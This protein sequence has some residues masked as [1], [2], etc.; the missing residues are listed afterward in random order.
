DNLGDNTFDTVELYSDVGADLWLHYFEDRSNTL[1]GGTFGNITDSRL[2]I[3]GIP[4]GT[5]PQEEINAIFTMI[6][7]APGSSNLPGDIPDRLSFI[8][9]IKNF[10]GDS[11]ANENDLTLPVNPAAP[12]ATLIMVAGTERI[13]SLSYNSTLMRGGYASDVSSLSIHVENLPEVLILKGSFQLSSTGLSRVNFNNPNLNTISQLLDNALLTVVEV[14]LDLGS[15]L[16]TLP[17]LIVGTAGS[18]G[19]ELEVLCLSQVRQTWNDGSVRSPSSLGVISMAIG[20]SDHPWL[21]DSDHILLSQDTEIEQVD[22]RDGPIEPLVPVAMSLRISN[23]SRVFQSYDPVTSIRSLELGGQQSGA[24]LVGHI[25]HSGTDFSDVTAQ[26]AMISNR[27]GLLSVVQD[28]AKLVYTASEPIGT[29][30]YGGEQGAQRN[31]IRLEGLPAA[32]QLNLGDSVGFQADTP[33]TSIMVQMTNA[34][35]PLTMD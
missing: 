4:S 19:G 10:S 15:I 12:P 35:T 30:T 17:D 13:R 7:E 18:S 24:L 28:P 20:S 6:G 23:I 32:F 22:G 11:T 14:V 26:S 21:T 25:R 27:P 29:I 2:W 5:L 1:E 9:A 31:A 8:L 34:T 33:I 16:N 3:R